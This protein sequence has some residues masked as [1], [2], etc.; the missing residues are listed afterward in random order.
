MV[1]LTSQPLW[2]LGALVV[3]ATLAAMAGSAVMRRHVGLERLSANN[4]VAGFKFA[5]LGVLYAVLLAFGVVVVWE[6]FNDAE[7]AVAQEA[8]AAAAIYGLAQGIGTGPG[9]AVR[10]RLSE[11]LEAAVADDWPAMAQGRLSPAGTRALDDLYAT[12]V[13]VRP[14]DIREATILTEI[15][16]QLDALTQARRDRLVMASGT[17]PG[18]I[19][20]VLF[21]G[22][23]LTVGFTFFFGTRNVWAQ[24][25]MT[26]A[27]ALLIFASLF[28]VVAIDRPFVGS[29]EVM[30]E[31]LA[32][33]LADFTKAPP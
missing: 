18:V 23:V 1:F 5:T 14:G 20:L 33:V 19:W 11:Y 27:L 25:T 21:G 28:V 2:V 9:E 3:L 7:N 6:R 12:L 15:L 30:P 8:S 22:A 31:P 13:N 24:A 26:G 17:V 32:A 10:T 29:V 16:R 4:E